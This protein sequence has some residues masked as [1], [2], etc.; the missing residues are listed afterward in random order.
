MDGRKSHFVGA[1]GLLSGCDFG[2]F[3]EKVSRC[4]EFLA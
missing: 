4:D 1:R 3:A 2:T